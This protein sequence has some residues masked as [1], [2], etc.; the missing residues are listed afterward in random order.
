[1]N[2]LIDHLPHPATR[3]IR[4]AAEAA[5][6]HLTGDAMSRHV[7]AYPERSD[8]PHR[9][10]GDSASRV[11]AARDTILGLSDEEVES[12]LLACIERDPARYDALLAD[13]LKDTARF[14]AA[15][16]SADMAQLDDDPVAKRVAEDEAGAGMAD[17]DHDGLG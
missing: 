13:V 10:P 15:P 3:V 1:M 7:H 4:I 14:L 12:T 9:E 5:R 2:H 16:A 6:A 11:R 17:N 8:L